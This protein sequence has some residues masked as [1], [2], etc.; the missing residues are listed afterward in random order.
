MC[1]KDITCWYKFTAPFLIFSALFSKSTLIGI[2]WRGP[3]IQL[4]VCM[5]A[6]LSPHF[7]YQWTGLDM[8][9]YSRDCHHTLFHTHSHTHTQS[10]T[11]TGMALRRISTQITLTQFY[12]SE[13]TQKAT[14][15]LLKRTK[16]GLYT[17]FKYETFRKSFK[18]TWKKYR[19]V[20]CSLQIT[21]WRI[22]YISMPL[23]RII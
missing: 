10:H 7:F 6:K 11:L 12:S 16:E 21:G 20:Y 15:K 17:F 23:G 1:A 18:S 4:C 5:G 22:H 9:L 2:G 19:R 14:D 3:N 13:E 8:T